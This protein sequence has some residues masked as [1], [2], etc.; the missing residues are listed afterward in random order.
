[1]VVVNGLRIMLRGRYFGHGVADYVDCVAVCLNSMH[2]VYAV[3]DKTQ[4]A[5]RTRV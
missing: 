1:M 2:I 4:R 5:Q 3:Q